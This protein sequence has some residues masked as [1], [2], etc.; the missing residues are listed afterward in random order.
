VDPTELHADLARRLTPQVAPHA[1]VAD[2]RQSVLAVCVIDDVDLVPLHAGV[3]GETSG[4]GHGDVLVEWDHIAAATAE[5]DPLSPTGR[6]AVGR[7]LRL[8]RDLAGRPDP[9][10]RDVLRP[11]A[12]PAGHALHPGVRWLREVPM[13]C[14]LGL[15]L[16]LLGVEGDPDLVTLPPAGLLESLDIDVDAAWKDA[17]L[18]LEDMGAIAAE[19]LHRD[20]LAPLRPMGDCDV[21]TL[22]GSTT[23]RRALVEQD[24]VGVRALAAPMRRRGWVDPDHVDA[25]FSRAAAAA[26]DPPERGFERP[27]LVTVD[28]VWEALDGDHQ[29]A[30][31]LALR[32]EIRAGYSVPPYYTD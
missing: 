12:L 23:F 1:A 2:L 4:A 18:Y 20:P 21:L 15:G 24:G 3:L 9:L 14:A 11:V 17:V 16:G 19:R 7:L 32:E 8:A 28:G 13:G 30:L 6:A 25:V 10:L 5:H 26:T 22:L 29:R 27:V 31:E